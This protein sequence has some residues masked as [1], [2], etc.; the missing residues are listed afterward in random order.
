MRK[1]IWFFAVALCRVA[2][3]LCAEPRAAEREWLSNEE[4]GKQI[5]G[6]R[7]VLPTESLPKIISAID[8]LDAETKGRL[9]ALKNGIQT[10]P[11]RLKL[12]DV[13]GLS[14][15]EKKELAWYYSLL[16][17]NADPVVRFF[18]LI[19]KVMV[20]KDKASATNLFE[21]GHAKTLGKSDQWLVDNCLHGVGLD[22]EKDT[23]E[24]IFRFI[25]T[26]RDEAHPAIGSQ[27]PDFSIP[28]L[29][30]KTQTL[31]H[32]KGKPVLIHFW[33]TTCGPCIAE[34][35][36]LERQLHAWKVAS[37]DLV[38][39]GISLDDD[40]KDVA[41]FLQKYRFDWTACCDR[42]GWGGEAARAY[43]ITAI[44]NDVVI[45][46]EGKIVAY[47]RDAVARSSKTGGN[48]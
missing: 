44:P 19:P 37:P 8:S 5:F 9:A 36:E 41:K 6:R 3:A 27:A 23:P 2:L 30:G 11:Q 46:P 10:N 18:G 14:N 47:S 4:M 25:S 45:D 35:P 32:F 26:M 39:L 12:I 16:A 15:V 21:L 13:A 38:V 24:T 20:L 29:D 1:R 42:R 28:T 34:F 40:L 7:V 17:T 43:H 33:S 31:S 22:V 48:R